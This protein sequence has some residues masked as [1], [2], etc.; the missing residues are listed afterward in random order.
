MVSHQLIN[1]QLVVKFKIMWL[2][3]TAL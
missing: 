2:K 3:L 1:D